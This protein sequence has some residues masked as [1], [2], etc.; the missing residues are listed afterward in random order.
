MDIL[1]DG[2]GSDPGFPLPNGYSGSTSRNDFGS[3]HGAGGLGTA[4]LG[5][6]L[7]IPSS[8]RPGSSRQGSISNSNSSH[9]H[10]HHHHNSTNFP[11]S[12]P[13][14]SSSSRSSAYGHN[15][16]DH[17]RPT[18]NN[19]PG[20]KT[21]RAPT[22]SPIGSPSRQARTGSGLVPPLP[23]KLDYTR[24]SPHASPRGS[25]VKVDQV[26]ARLPLLGPVIPVGAGGRRR[27]SNKEGMDQDRRSHARAQGESPFRT[28]RFESAIV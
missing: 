11:G 26:G 28:R 25:F 24:R 4:G 21:S 2:F 19:N 9:G 15:R 22:P 5:S 7:P 13:G 17:E 1:G 3:D 16:E 20:T 8:S 6:R 23:Q 10:G 18:N 14:S 27:S 12:R